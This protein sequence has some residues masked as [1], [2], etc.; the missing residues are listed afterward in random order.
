MRGGG[1]GGGG[2]GGVRDPG[3]WEGGREIGDND[4]GI[5]VYYHV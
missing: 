5:S 2:G 1:G 3:P 4:S